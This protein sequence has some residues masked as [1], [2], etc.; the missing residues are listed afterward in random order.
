[1]ATS[2]L[3]KGIMAMAMPEMCSCDDVVQNLYC[4]SVTAHKEHEN[5]V[6]SK[7]YSKH[8]ALGE[9]YEGVSSLKDRVV[10]YM[11]GQDY[12]KEVSL[13]EIDSDEDIIDEANE[14][15]STLQMFSRMKG[16]DALINMSG[17]LK[18]LVGKLKYM[19]KFA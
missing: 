12:I 18:E 10:E 11:I 13:E 6:L 3:G 2:T 15:V 1:M 7:S 9:F 19:L 14:A 17:D 16:D 4:L 8:V 5:A